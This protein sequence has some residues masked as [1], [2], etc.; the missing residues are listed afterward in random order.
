MPVHCRARL[1]WCLARSDWDQAEWRRI[2]LSGESRFQLCHD[3][4]R[5]RVWRRPGVV[6]PSFLSGSTAKGGPWPSQEAYARRTF[7]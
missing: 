6:F 7:F 2:V 4:N 3:D 1:Q 5:K